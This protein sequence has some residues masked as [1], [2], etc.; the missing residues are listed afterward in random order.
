MPFSL[1][2]PRSLERQGWKVKI[3]DRERLEPP[4]VTIIQGTRAWR[5]DLRTRTLMDREPDAA[6][7]APG[8]MAEV[9][10]AW[11]TLQERWN[12][13]YPENPVQSKERDDE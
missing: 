1:R 9:W 5:V 6:D 12:E 13:M 10:G 4:H 11:E 2:L 7:V 3:R 8:V